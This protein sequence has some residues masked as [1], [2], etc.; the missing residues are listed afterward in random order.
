MFYAEVNDSMRVS[1]GEILARYLRRSIS[2]GGGHNTASDIEPIEVHYEPIENLS[3]LLYDDN[4]SRPPAFLFGV[5]W[6][7]LNKVSKFA[8]PVAKD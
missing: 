4:I 8:S 1:E 3:R 7:L 2:T 6:F 5:T